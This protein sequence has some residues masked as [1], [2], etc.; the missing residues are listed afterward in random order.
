MH[1]KLFRSK[2]KIP[3]IFFFNLLDVHQSQIVKIIKNLRI[4]LMQ[5]IQHSDDNNRKWKSEQYLQNHK[6]YIMA[7]LLWDGM[8]IIL[9]YYA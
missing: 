1:D 7:F 9:D 2:S 4:L 3:S 5:G 6:N 8:R